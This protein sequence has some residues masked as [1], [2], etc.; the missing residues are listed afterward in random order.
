MVSIEVLVAGTDIVRTT[1]G[2]PFMMSYGTPK[3]QVYGY[4]QQAS[5]CV[6]F[7]NFL[8]CFCG[9]L[10]K[11]VVAVA[12]LLV[13]INSNVWTWVAL[14]CAKLDKIEKSMKKTT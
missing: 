11:L 7:K 3:L 14:C 1:N 9:Y 13:S 2:Q 5:S 8:I 4:L 12:V 6:G 10:F